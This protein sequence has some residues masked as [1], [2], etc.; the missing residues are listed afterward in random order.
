MPNMFAFFF[1]VLNCRTRR[2]VKMLVATLLFVCLFV[3]A[4]GY[5]ALSTGDLTSPYLLAQGDDNGGFFYRLIGRGFINDPNDFAQ[6][7]VSLLP[8]LFFFWKPKRGFANTVLVLVPAAV[9]IFGLYLTHSRGAMLALLLV[10]LLSAR[11]KIGTI[12]SSVIAALLFMGTLAVGWTGGR[13]VSMEAGSDRMDAWSAGLEMIKQHPVFGVGFGAF[14]EH[15]YLTAHNTIIVCAAELGG[16]GL[17][18]W[19]LFVCG[20]FWETLVAGSTEIEDKAVAAGEPVPSFARIAVVPVA[21]A[22]T[23]QKVSAAVSPHL[24]PAASGVGALSPGAVAVPFFAVRNEET[25]SS[26]AEEIRRLARVMTISLAGFL[27]AGWF[28]SRAFQMTI[29]V[30]CGII[31]VIYQL[32]SQRGMV[33]AKMPIKKLMRI[34][35]V[36]GIG[37]VF[38]VYLM[39]LV[40][41]RMGVY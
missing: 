13:Q 11:R 35:L 41:H 33:P 26:I 18:L 36:S 31:E 23:A 5:F 9:L 16:V 29:F 21:S 28:L 40:A 14:T 6:L 19:L 3:I 12:A 24:R 2:Q 17:F 15:Y 7:L 1:I 27:A 30:Y 10:V 37:L 32:A 4:N 25:D 34:A 22:S 20:A 39:L 38:V 8:G